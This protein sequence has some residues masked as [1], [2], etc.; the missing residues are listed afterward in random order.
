MADLA[1][2]RNGLVYRY[3]DADDGLAGGE[4][5]FAI[6]TFWLVHNYVLQGRLTEAEALFRHVRSFA[7][8]VGLFAEEIDPVTGEQLGNFPQAFTHIA[9]INAAVRLAAAH[10]GE[11]PITH[12]IVEDAHLPQERRGARWEMTATGGRYGRVSA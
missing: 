4:G 8:D 6:C 5:T 9:L 2:I 7:N 11:K 3:L 12:A 10:R 1:G